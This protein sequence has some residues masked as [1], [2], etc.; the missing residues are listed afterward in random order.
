MKMQ[1][2]KSQ[3]FRDLVW[4][5]VGVFHC[6]EWLCGQKKTGLWVKGVNWAVIWTRALHCWRS[7]DVPRC[8]KDSYSNSEGPGWSPRI[9]IPA[10]PRDALDHTGLSSRGFW[11]PAELCFSCMESVSPV[12]HT[13]QALASAA[14]RQARCV[15][16]GGGRKWQ[17]FLPQVAWRKGPGSWQPVAQTPPRASSGPGRL[18]ATQ[19]WCYLV[20]CVNS[21][22]GTSRA[23]QQ[24]HSAC[25]ILRSAPVS[26]HRQVPS[27]A[28][29]A[30][31]G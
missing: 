6:E 29:Q 9:C 30:T 1:Y 15:C 25:F 20:L 18:G 17:N 12:S 5:E 16:E 13:L 21:L 14:A 27:S 2:K 23:T 31:L 19:G 10:A 4:W 22:V 11:D 3:S 28:A 26:D 24:N 8:C 7:H